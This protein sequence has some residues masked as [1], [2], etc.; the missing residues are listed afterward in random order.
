MAFSQTVEYALR[1]AAWLAANPGRPQ[2]TQQVADATAVPREYLSKVLQSL[3]RQGIVTSQRGVG[4]GFK[5]AAD[6]RDITILQV[7]NAI[8]PIERL[9][10]CPLGKGSHEKLCPL[11]TKIDE[12]LAATE[13]IC[14]KTTLLDLLERGGAS[15]P[16]CGYP[17][18][19]NITIDADRP[20]AG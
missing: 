20:P 18:G 13:R 15:G 11:H 3:G 10:C 8:E 9:N 2:T 19:V 5:L 16:I 4:G 7:V 12:M 6:P 17:E 1:A 14:S